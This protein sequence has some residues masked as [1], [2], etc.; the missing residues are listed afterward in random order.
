MGT[1]TDASY[2]EKVE[3]TL[4]VYAGVAGQHGIFAATY[5]LAVMRF[6]HPH[7]QVVIFGKD[8]AAAELYRAAVRP[9]G[10]NTAV[11]RLD[12]DKAV[13]QNCRRLWR[14]RFRT[15][16]SCG[17]AV[18]CGGVLGVRLPSSDFEAEELARAL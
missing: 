7:T 12:A 1:R 18:V 10:L 9:L 17:G 13:G 6:L 8:E 5:G 4:E 14:R 2:R 3:Q 16:R 15:F 11:L